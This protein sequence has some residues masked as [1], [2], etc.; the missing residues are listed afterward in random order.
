MKL[1]QSLNK[2]HGKILVPKQA[3][4]PAAAVEIPESTGCTPFGL[5]NVQMS[6]IRRPSVRAAFISGHFGTLA[7]NSRLIWD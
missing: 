5:L 6:T 1:S 7:T 4:N 3:K 2:K